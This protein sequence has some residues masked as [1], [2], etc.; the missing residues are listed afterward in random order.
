MTVN[1][2]SRSDPCHGSER[3]RVDCLTAHETQLRGRGQGERGNGGTRGVFPG[4]TSVH[5]ETDNGICA[6]SL[7]SSRKRQWRIPTA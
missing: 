2:R 7:V 5:P 4:R 3:R 6:R 1:V